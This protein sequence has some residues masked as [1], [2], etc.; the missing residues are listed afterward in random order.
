MSTPSPVQPSADAAA[1]LEVRDLRVT[2]RSGTGALH[3]VDGVN[4]DLAPGEFL[5]VVG[6]S[7][8]GKTQLLLAMLGLNAPGAKVTGS[9]RYRGQEL[10]GAGERMLAGLRGARIAMIFQDPM[11]ALNP[12]LT[13]GTQL[14]EGLRHHQG[15]SR[16]VARQRALELLDAVH[17]P[18]PERR[19]AQHPHELSGGMRQRVVIAMALICEPD[20]LLADEPTTALDVTVQA[21]ILALLRELRTRTRAAIMLVTHDLGVIA[22]IADRVLV[23]YAGR[24]VEQ[25][26][27]QQLFETARHPYTEALRRSIVPLRGPLPERLPSIGGNPPNPAALPPGCAFAPRC[28]Y[29]FDRCPTAPPPLTPVSDGHLSACY[30]DGPL[31]RIR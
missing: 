22:E 9:I 1:L 12:Y 19:F 24:V 28:A 10:V 21:Q 11:T 20:V 6:E 3:A 31:G 26:G 30:Y 17:I 13:I 18:E 25:A 14:T 4:V 7:G 8:S 27:V 16:A 29:V 2:Y 23:M 15:A 5:G